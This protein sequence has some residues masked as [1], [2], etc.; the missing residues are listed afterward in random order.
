MRRRHGT[1]QLRSKVQKWL[2]TKDITKQVNKINRE[3]GKNKRK[4]IHKRNAKTLQELLLERQIDPK[5]GTY[6]SGIGVTGLIT[7]KK[8]SKTRAWC[9]CGGKN[10]KNKNSKHCLLG[11]GDD[12]IMKK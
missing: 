2:N 1:P 4:R 7:K 5:A 9:S 6:C 3:L 12:A 10:H 11:D 8:K